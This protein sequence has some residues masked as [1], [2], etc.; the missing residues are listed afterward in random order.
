MSLLAD[1]SEGSK[2]E[3]RSDRL[4]TSPLAES[5]RKKQQL[6][7]EVKKSPRKLGEKV[8]MAKKGPEKKS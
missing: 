7:S 8:R 4:R 6:L 5:R 2:R 3:E 1:V